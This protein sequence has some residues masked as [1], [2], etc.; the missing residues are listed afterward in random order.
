MVHSGRFSSLASATSRR[1]PLMMLLQPCYRSPGY[2]PVS[3][4]S[5][6]EKSSQAQ[7][8][9]SCCHTWVCPPPSVGFH[10]DGILGPDGLLS[11]HVSALQLPYVTVWGGGRGLRT[12]MT[13]VTYPIPSPANPPRPTRSEPAGEGP[14]SEANADLHLREQSQP[15]AEALGLADLTTLSRARELT[16]ECLSFEISQKAGGGGVQPLGNRVYVIRQNGAQPELSPRCHQRHYGDSD[17]LEAEEDFELHP[18]AA[19]PL[20][21]A[22]RG[23]AG[24]AASRRQEGARKPCHTVQPRRPTSRPH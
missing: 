11:T 22:L 8:N 3:P 4:I 1:Q 19:F 2:E 20:T 10:A 15:A 7:R 9:R 16:S 6:P 21:S 5:I 13:G 17:F 12:S 18:G 14:G 24:A 23:A